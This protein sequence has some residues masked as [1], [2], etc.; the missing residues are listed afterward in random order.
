MQVVGQWTPQQVA[1]WIASFGADFSQYRAAIESNGINGEALLDDF[2]DDELD[3]INVEK[4]SHRKRILRE[5][6]KLS[7]KNN[8]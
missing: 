8:A 4:K 6:N 1:S 7:M 3:D 5:T 2:G